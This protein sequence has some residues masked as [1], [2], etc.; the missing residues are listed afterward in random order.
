M[1][2]KELG[3]RAADLNGEDSR[4]APVPSSSFSYLNRFANSESS[5]D[6]E[7]TGTYLYI[8]GAETVLC[9]VFDEMSFKF[10][11][12]CKFTLPYRLQFCILSI[13]FSKA[14]VLVLLVAKACGV[15]LV[16]F[17]LMCLGCL[18]RHPSYRP[19]I[20]VIPRARTEKLRVLG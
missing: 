3:N 13:P 6:E 12:I 5:T 20:L 8:A 4:S 16:G 7:G 19:Q 9:I 1:P 15:I 11:M 14:A 17:T 18:Q 2:T 10:C